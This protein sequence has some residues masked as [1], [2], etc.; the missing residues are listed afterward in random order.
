MVRKCIPLIFSFCVFELALVASDFESVSLEHEEDKQRIYYI[1]VEAHEGILMSDV[2]NYLGHQFEIHVSPISYWSSDKEWM[3]VSY[4]QAN[5][6]KHQQIQALKSIEVKNQKIKVRPMPLE[7]NIEDEST[8][9]FQEFVNNC[10]VC[11]CSCT[12]L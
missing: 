9:L 8:A 4:S 12:L 6:E 3:K 10:C 2:S 1:L 5:P 7:L 11:D